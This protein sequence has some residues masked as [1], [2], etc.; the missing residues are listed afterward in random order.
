MFIEDGV[1]LHVPPA[2]AAT[3]VWDQMTSSGRGLR[4]QAVPHTAEAET[5]EQP[6]NLHKCVPDMNS[7]THGRV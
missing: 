2:H 5:P 4:K 3:W 7:A 1:D 6:L